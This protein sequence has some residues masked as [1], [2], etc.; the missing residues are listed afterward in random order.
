M[1]QAGAEHMTRVTVGEVASSNASAVLASHALVATGGASAEAVAGGMNHVFGAQAESGW[2]FVPVV[3]TIRAWRNAG[4][5][6]TSQ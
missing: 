3:G 4:G 6:C 2:G 5:S 1:L